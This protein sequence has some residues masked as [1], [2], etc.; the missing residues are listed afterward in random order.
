MRMSSIERLKKHILSEPT[1]DRIAIREE[2][3]H[4]IQN[5]LRMVDFLQ[6]E[7]EVNEELLE[8]SKKMYIYG[9]LMDVLFN[10]IQKQKFEWNDLYDLILEV[11]IED[12]I[13]IEKNDSFDLSPNATPDYSWI[14]ETLYYQT[15]IIWIFYKWAPIFLNSNYG[16]AIGQKNI[17]TLKEEIKAGTY[18]SKYYKDGEDKKAQNAV[19]RLQ[20]GQKYKNLVLEMKNGKKISWNSFGNTDGLEIRIWLDVTAGKQEETDIKHETQSSHINTQEMVELYRWKVR[21]LI[22]EHEGELLSNQDYYEIFKVLTKAIDTIWN[23]SQYMI[24]IINN[25]QDDSWKILFNPQ[26]TKYLEKSTEEIEA[27]AKKWIL[28]E[29]N[30]CQDTIGDIS[31]LVNQLKVDGGSYMCDFTT[32]NGKTSSW[33]RVAI[34]E[35]ELGINI[36]IGIGSDVPTMVDKELLKCLEN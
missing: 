13:W 31:T 8:I 15:P 23:N 30:Y 25:N 7:K 17:N 12:L 34:I 9:A 19:W 4:T 35:P 21:G 24:N 3:G 2:I 26:Y 1:W 18:F 22:A 29:R 6:P 14:N 10:R 33:Y 20:N 28:F 5:I 16:T 32:K 36:T 11:N 27:E